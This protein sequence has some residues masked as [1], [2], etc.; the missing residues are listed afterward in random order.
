MTKT[1]F[2]LFLFFLLGVSLPAKAQFTVVNATV[3]DPNGSPY[4]NC[5]GSASFVP[6]PSATLAPTISGSTFPTVVV[7][8]SCDSFARFTLT[9]V[10]NNQV[11]DGHT[12]P[13]ASQ[14]NFA[15]QSQDGKTG[16]NCVMTITG[17]SQDISS[18][19]Q[20]CAAPLPASAGGGG[21]FVVKPI[22]CASSMTFTLAG[23]S[24]TTANTA[25][26][27]TLNCNVASTS[28]VAGSGNVQVGTVAQFTLIQD[29][30]GGRTFNWPSNF[31]DQ[32]T[33]QI[34]PLS[35]TNASFYF[36]GI[37][38]HAQTF[39]ASGGGGGNPAPPEQAVQFRSNSQFAGSSNLLYHTSSD[40]LDMGSISP[41]GNPY[42]DVAR[43]GQSNSSNS[44]TAN[45]TTGSPN[46]TLASAIDFQDASAFPVT[47]TGNGIVI[48]QCGAATGLS[49][50]NAPTVTPK[51]ITSGS[52]T[53]NYNWVAEDLS[54]GLTAASAAGATTTGAATLGVNSITLTQGVWSSTNNGTITFTCSVN[55]CGIS[56]LVPININWSGTNG[57]FGGNFTV[58]S[59][60]T[61]T[62]TVLSPVVPALTTDTGGGTL[63]IEACNVLTA[64]A[65]MVPQTVEGASSDQVMRWWVY[66]NNVL[67]AVIQHRDAYYTDC[68]V[69]TPNFPTYLPSSP[70]AAVNKYLAT[71]IVSGGGTVNLVLAANAGN[72]ISGQTAL[73]DNSTNLLAALNSQH[74][75]TPVYLNGGV[76]NAATIFDTRAQNTKL[77]LPVGISLRAPW[78]IKGSGFSIE[79]GLG[80]CA[81]SFQFG[82]A[83]T[84]SGAGNSLSYPVIETLTPGSGTA[85]YT[86]EQALNNVTLSN[87]I[88]NTNS[89]ANKIAFSMD[90]NGGFGVQLLNVS[91]IGPPGSTYQNMPAARISGV[92]HGALTGNGREWACSVPQAIL[93]APC[94]RF[95]NQSPAEVSGVASTVAHTLIT[96]G[97]MQGNGFQI[98]CL[99]NA[100]NCTGGFEITMRKMLGEQRF[101][102]FLRGAGG[103]SITGVSMDNVDDDAPNAGSGNAFVDNAACT[104]GSGAFFS[105]ANLTS[106]VSSQAFL[107]GPGNLSVGQSVSLPAGGVLNG[108]GNPFGGNTIVT[109]GQV[110]TSGAGAGIQASGS[111]AIGYALTKPVAPTVV[112]GGSGSCSS[113][114]IAAGTYVYAISAIDTA[115]R[116]SVLGAVSAPQTTDG[117]Q[118][119][120]VSWTPQ[121]GQ[122]TTNRCRGPN[123]GNMG[124]ATPLGS[125][126]FVGTSYS[127]T[128]AVGN[129]VSPPLQ[130][131]GNAESISSAGFAGHQ[132]ILIDPTSSFKSTMVP[133][134]ITANRTQTFP[135][136]TGTIANLNLAQTWTD[137]QSIAN[138]KAIRWFSTNG[139]N[140]AG[141]TG[142]A[143][144]TNLVWLF[145][146]TDSSGTQCL[147]SNGSLQ[148]SWSACSGGT[149]T[150]GGSN[151][152][153]QFN[154]SAS[155]GGSTNLTWVSPT[156]TIGSSG[157]TGNLSLVGGTSG[158]VTLTSQAAAG[159]PTITFGTSSG[160]PAVTASSPLGITAA[161][162]NI[163]CAT[164]TTNAAA[165]TNN[166]I[167]L[168]AGSQATQIGPAGTTTTVL[169]GNAA[170]A[171]SYTAVDL[172][173]DTASTLTV[174]KGGTGQTTANAAFNALTPMTTEGDLEYFHT[175]SGTRLA[176]GSNGQCLTSNGTD[177]AWGSCA[178][179]AVGG[180]AVS[181]QGTF[182]NGTGTV[183]GSANW[184]Y[185]AASGHTVTQGANA[186]DA[187]L[188]FRNTDTSPSGNFLHFKNAANN[189]DIFKLDVAGN[190]T[191]TGS[192]SSLSSTAG[193]IQLGQGTAPGLVANALQ[194]I[195]PASVTAA[196]EQFA[197]PGNPGTGVLRF[198]NSAGAMAGSLVSASGV[199]SCA[200]TV[201]T[202]VNDNAAPSCSPVLGAD[203]GSQTAN[204]FFAAPNGS[205]GNPAFRAIVAADLLPINLASS[206][207]GGVSGVLGFANG[208]CNATSSASCFN[209]T[210]PMTTLGDTIYGGS[211][212]AG[213]GTRLP[214]NT[215]ATKMYLTQTG[216]GSVSAAP[217]WAQGA[218]GDLSGT[219]TIG[220]GGTGQT[221]APAAFNALSPMNTLGDIIY[222]AASGAG[223]R[224]AGNTTVTTLCLTQ[225]GNGSVSAAPAWGSCAGAAG[226]AW[227][228]LT[229]PSG[230]L[231]IS[232]GADTTT[233]TWGNA[234]GAATDM[235]KITDTASNTGT[236]FAFNVNLAS[237]SAA[238]PA[239]LAVNGNGV[240][241][242][243]AG[244]LAKVGTGSI[245]A[246]TLNLNVNTSSP[247]TGGGALSSS[248][249][250]ACATCVTSAA[251]I[252]NNALVIGSGGGQGTAALGSLGTTTTVLHG[253]AAGSPSFGSIVGADM[254]NNTVTATQL[255]A[256]YSVGSCTEVWGGTGAAFV[257][258]TGDDSISNNTCYNDSGVTRT[259]TAVKCRSDAA[260]N[261]TTVNPTFG[262]A[263]TGTTIGNGTALTCGSSL[264]YSA[265]I[266]L[267]NTA[268][269]TGTG[270]NPVMGGTLTGTSIAM[271]VEY[272]Y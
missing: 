255:A 79:G 53:Y 200:N 32:P 232:M 198:T 145:P 158:N 108:P 187:L 45:C 165:L 237:S 138:G 8:A 269:T 270:I 129:T 242:S 217:A 271:I 99:P 139:T 207:N 195:A 224:L 215:S 20:A 29:A 57:S 22:P 197:F 231:A 25:F 246:D 173:N 267:T 265:S 160:T 16:F 144:T 7:I 6:S 188:M 155:F 209:N 133:G 86:N 42:V 73:H 11:S 68:G 47:N 17:A 234:T 175:S 100:A 62:F 201:V 136:N 219:A 102:P 110:T 37:A 151:T 245:T 69:N 190:L 31:I 260:S 191:T 112:F 147:S 106:S 263:G 34:A 159:T 243:N 166:L 163:T 262:S 52:T 211:S 123:A 41:L 66:R 30:V 258:T 208:G 272:T 204:T 170:G 105:V 220:Q 85:S 186:A 113:N 33:V 196:G 261:T 185:S 10:D 38:W 202:A 111:S 84:I 92:T 206:A 199:G 238:K 3:L 103:C 181:G 88:I 228:S 240:S 184:T 183:T 157:T 91:F 189:S 89:A 97:N 122:V 76:F 21:A 115:N 193:T 60:S 203:F 223:T 141:F 176:V 64:P 225:T 205:A 214:G 119:I 40:R 35:T 254:T 256:Q 132:A 241:V 1:K 24:P 222:G 266:T 249:T 65:G 229:S 116:Y 117:T 180:S 161:T 149:G 101:G 164:C 128:T 96:E 78:V 70:G 177:P 12:S 216:N 233:F 135:D 137:H 48:Y 212:P 153:V 127:D 154:N 28:V 13:P 192:I 257:L 56:N 253:N 59:V 50:P 226:T 27:T 61:N 63:K 148:L 109:G 150:P 146:T 247:L 179:G 167:V 75:G 46:V 58:T 152:E 244:V 218:F 43:W 259:I 93:V 194:L 169:H 18:A 94:I 118:S 213:G 23:V 49:T 210:S 125:A 268:W 39:P 81:T 71:T 87:L 9:L 82:C 264:A 80:N 95:T 178:A 14:W 140:Y 142:G 5:S 131:T 126:G 19:L 44:T 4:S 171:P 251:A 120:T 54:G 104:G 172:V 156:L 15:I 26:T 174:A 227:S 236:G 74:S 121:N 2:L 83:I 239:Q 134:T 252:T 221:T 168:G 230:N 235:F 90:N 248:L 124:C 182:W 67:A 107:V 250:L 72:T 77:L 130:T 162:G 55:P 98:D 143:S 114:C 36:D 51:G